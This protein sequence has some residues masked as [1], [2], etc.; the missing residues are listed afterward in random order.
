[1]FTLK[2]DL[3][4]G[5]SLPGDERGFFERNL[6]KFKELRAKEQNK[7]SKRQ[8]CGEVRGAEWSDV[9]WVESQAS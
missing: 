6:G 9:A 4:P 8:V 1:M 2:Y 7:K 3:I 5:I